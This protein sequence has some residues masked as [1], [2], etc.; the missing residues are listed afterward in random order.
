MARRINNCLFY[1]LLLSVYAIFF[2]V[3]FYNHD[4]QSEL[5][6]EISIAK[7]APSHASST[8]TPSTHTI[9]LNKRFHQENIQPC[10]VFCVEAPKQ[11]D[12]PA[13][14]GHYRNVFLSSCFPAHTPL[15]GPPVVA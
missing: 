15:R 7:N 3:Q 1:T 2:S 11:Y 13:I 4:G 8:H 10:M 6:R 12:T 14:L 9:R 5:R